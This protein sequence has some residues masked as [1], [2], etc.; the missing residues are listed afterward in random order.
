MLAPAD[1]TIPGLGLGSVG[2]ALKM[3][4]LQFITINFSIWWLSRKQGWS[5]DFSYQLIGLGLFLLL[6]L[7]SYQVINMLIS[8]AVHV[9]IRGS[10]AG[11]VYFLLTVI[12]FYKVPWLIGMSSNEIKEYSN[13]CV[14]R[15]IK[16]D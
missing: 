9:L 5:F 13:K 16:D 15:L 3:V 1:A 11:L 2:L 12:I 6:G 7:I 4:I 10:I 8:D 14:K